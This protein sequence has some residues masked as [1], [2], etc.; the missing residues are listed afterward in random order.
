M[1]AF[2]SK[3]GLDERI[4]NENAPARSAASK[5]DRQITHGLLL[6]SDTRH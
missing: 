6:C 4:D 5:N 1:A 3:L 2:L